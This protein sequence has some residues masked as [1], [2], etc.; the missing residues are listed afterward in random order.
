LYGTWW[1]GAVIN[2]VNIRWSA[3]EVAYSLDDCDTRV[4]LVD[5]TF[6]RLAQDVQPLSQSLKTL[7]YVG[8]G[9]TPD[10]ML[11]FNELV[12]A[13]EP[14]ADAMRRGDDLAAVMYTGGTTG[15]PKGVMLSHGNL[16]T[17]QLGA[18]A[19][20]ARPENAIG[21][22]AAPMFHVGGIGLVL[23]L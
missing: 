19:G 22:H 3:R 20:A 10:G 12:A 18:I 14:V 21:L 4:L 6:V 7:V 9:H 15:L 5:D 1:A 16:Y 13:A 8:S 11:D 2:P 23:Q 17:G